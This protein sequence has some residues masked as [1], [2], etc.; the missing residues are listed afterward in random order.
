M[1]KEEDI[2]FYITWSPAASYKN[3]DLCPGKKSVQSIPLVI[4]VWSSLQLCPAAAVNN[5]DAALTLCGPTYH[6]P[7]APSRLLTVLLFT[8]Q[9]TTLWK[10]LFPT[11]I[12]WIILRVCTLFQIL[13]FSCLGAWNEISFNHT[14]SFHLNI[15]ITANQQGPQCNFW[16]T[17]LIWNAKIY[18]LKG[19]CKT[20]TTTNMNKE[21]LWNYILLAFS[22]SFGFQQIWLMKQGHCESLSG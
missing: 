12:I 1:R 3:P 7:S 15:N 14:L 22:Y 18:R 5:K 21:V 2:D 19:V 6:N 10:P 9:Y 17:K 16:Q 13:Y 11:F 20:T 4:Y 8:F